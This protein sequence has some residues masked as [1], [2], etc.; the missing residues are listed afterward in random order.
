M[1]KVKNSEEQLKKLNKELEVSQEKEV[2]LDCQIEM[3]KYD[4]ELLKKEMEELE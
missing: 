3:E 2:D 1:E 4:I